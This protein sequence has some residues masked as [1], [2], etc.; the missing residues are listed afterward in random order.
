[1]FQ[2]LFC[3]IM[4]FSSSPLEKEPRPDILGRESKG[5]LFY[6][7][8]FSAHRPKPVLNMIYR[9]S[10]LNLEGFGNASRLS[11]YGKNIS[12]QRH[13]NK[14]STLLTLFINHE[15][16]SRVS[17]AIQINNKTLYII[18]RVVPC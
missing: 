10:Y 7:I 14:K 13:Y 5:D 6:V 2:G 18:T 8:R 1:M 15:I 3:V 4:F 16:Q 11:G 12:S 17:G 9:I